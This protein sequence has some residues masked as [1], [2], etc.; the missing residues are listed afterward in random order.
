MGFVADAC[1]V[2]FITLTLSFEVCT[3][4][5][6]VANVCL[7]FVM[8]EVG[9]T[10]ILSKDGLNL[11]YILAVMSYAVI[12]WVAERYIHLENFVSYRVNLSA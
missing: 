11:T 4:K 2:F 3:Y 5:L 12:S 1:S 10:C 6:S 7:S 8:K 9:L